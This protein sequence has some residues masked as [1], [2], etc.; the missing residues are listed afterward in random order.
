M[1]P[2]PYIPDSGLSVVGTATGA[3]PAIDL[4]L[5]ESAFGVSPLAVAAT[6]TRAERLHRYPDPASTELRAAIARM[7][8]QGGSALTAEDLVV[9][10]GAQEAIALGLRAVT[11][12][13]DTVAIESPTYHGFLQVLESLH[14]KALLLPTLSIPTNQCLKVRLE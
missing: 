11:K 1:R 14:L 13:G 7:A 2:Q 8:V 12:P 10:T 4:S 9:T 3:P 6:Q 5:N